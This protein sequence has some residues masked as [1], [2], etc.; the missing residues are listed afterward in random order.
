MLKKVRIISL[1]TCLFL[2][3]VTVSK[4]VVQLVDTESTDFRTDIDNNITSG[5]ITTGSGSPGDFEV[6]M[7]STSSNGSNSF[8][9][10]TPGDWLTID[11]GKCG[12]QGQCI[13]G[14]YG[15]FDEFSDSSDISCNWTN[16]TNVF[17]AGLFRYNGVDNNNPVIDVACNT[18]GFG[19]ILTAP[20]IITEPGSVVIRVFLNGTTEF[21]A[22]QSNTL[23]HGFFLAV[24]IS[25]QTGEFVEEM[26][27]SDTFLDGGA[28]GTI[29]FFQN[30]FNWRACTIALRMAPANIPTLSEGGL[31]V[32]T[33]L[34]AVSAAW[35]IKKR[36]TS[37]A[38]K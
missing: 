34:M 8:L 24:G 21:Q 15:R 25:N 28:T 22:F 5:L 32:F 31:F 38:Y 26:G 35:F 4:A 37:N 6:L 33:L 2:L 27:I 29:D 11:S 13:L 9:N 3:S 12:G 36:N 1:T 17:A 16:P 23:P 7:C 30:T 20:S 18:G 19:N 10:P 14:I